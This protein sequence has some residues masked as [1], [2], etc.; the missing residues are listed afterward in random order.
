VAAV[1]APHLERS[2]QSRLAGAG[3]TRNLDAYQP[4]LA[5]RQQAQ[6]LRTAGL[7][8]S[9]ALYQRAIALD[10]QYALAYSGMGESYRRMVFGS[11]GEPLRVLAEAARCNEQAVALDPELAEGHAGMGWMRFW[12]DWNWSA[13]AAAFERALALNASEAGAR[14]GSRC[15][16][17]PWGAAAMRW[18]TCAVHARATPCR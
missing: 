13:A 1:L 5:A 10:P 15:C 7:T 2:S 16:S 12:H 3:G 18:C 8:R 6:G 11:D 17:A 14:L 4:Y 9:I